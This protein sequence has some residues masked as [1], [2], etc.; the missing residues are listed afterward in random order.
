M[1]HH[2]HTH[3]ITSLNKAFIWGIALNVTFVIA[4]AIAGFLGNS[5]GLLADAGHNLSDVAS[6]ILSLIAFRMAKIHATKQFTYGYKKS[7]ILVSLLNAV[8]LLVA[9]IFIIIESIEKLLHP[10]TVAGGTIIWVAAIGVVINGITAYL[11]MADKDKDLNVKGAYLHMAADALVSIGV[12][13]SGV[14]ILFT[15]WYFIDAIIGMVVAIVIIISTWHLLSDSLRLALDGV[16]AAIDSD[17]VLAA[18]RSC[19]NVKE[20]HHCHIWAMST[21]E[22]AFTAHIVIDDIAKMEATKQAVKAK[23]L[24]FGIT[25][26]TLEFEDG[27]CECSDKGLNVGDID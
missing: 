4:E 24:E 19:D 25:H 22:N 10:E 13:I 21:T 9:V 23:L 15:D 2:H 17:K 8:I 11:F 26:A 27:S 20:I 7:T 12:V 5:M 1:E 14:I 6:L 18:A 3:E 16:P